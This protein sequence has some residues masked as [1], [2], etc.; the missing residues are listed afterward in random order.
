MALK[1]ILES[2]ELAK[3]IATIALSTEHLK[4]EHWYS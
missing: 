3:E 2:P 1:F 4:F